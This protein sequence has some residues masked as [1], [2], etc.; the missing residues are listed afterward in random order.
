MNLRE[1]TRR[2]ALLLGVAGA[3]AGV[4]VS[5]LEVQSVSTERAS[6]AKFEKFATSDV[7]EQL[8]KSQAGW[9]T[10]DPKTGERIE[11]DQQVGRGGIETIH[12]NADS[13]IAFIVTDDGHYLFPT[14]APAAWEYLLVVL[15]PILGF[16]VPWGAVRAIGWTAAG[17]VANAK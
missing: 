9:H 6:H 17:F 5:Y 2:L 4:F 10:V 14:P 7:V 15:F 8:R 13:A 1:G 16:I 11:W 3:I 12:W